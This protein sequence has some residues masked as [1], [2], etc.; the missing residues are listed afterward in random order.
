M[1]NFILVPIDYFLGIINIIERGNRFR[2]PQWFRI[3]TKFRKKY[4]HF[5]LNSLS[6]ILNKIIEIW[7]YVSNLF[8]NYNNFTYNIQ[9]NSYLIPLSHVMQCTFVCLVVSLIL[10][11]VSSS[12]FFFFIQEKKFYSYFSYQIQTNIL[13]EVVTQKH[14]HV[15]GR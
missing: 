10:T 1:I 5:F 6:F 15:Q 11:F 12:F 9:F 13:L 7:N 2:W 14:F 3:T 4:F 8:I